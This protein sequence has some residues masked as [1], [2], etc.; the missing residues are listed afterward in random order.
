MVI[1]MKMIDRFKTLGK[2]KK[3][4]IA[5]YPNTIYIINYQNIYNFTNSSCEIKL[6]DFTFKVKGLNLKIIRKTS[7]ELEINGIINQV[8]YIYE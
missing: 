6:K 2:E 4:Y 7:D 1:Y 8:E 3:Y 5:L